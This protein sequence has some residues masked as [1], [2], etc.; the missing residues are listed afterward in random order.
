MASWEDDREFGRRLRLA[1][2]SWWTAVRKRT[3]RFTRWILRGPAVWRTCYHSL[4]TAAL[5]GG[6]RLSLRGHGLVKLRFNAALGQ[7]CERVGVA[8]L[9]RR[10]TD[11]RI[12]E[13]PWPPPMHIVTKP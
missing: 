12:N 11:S 8:F 5:R 10:Y 13:I 9:R 1:Q 4:R 2:A 6:R 7:D 3:R